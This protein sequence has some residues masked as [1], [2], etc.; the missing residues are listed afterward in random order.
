MCYENIIIIHNCKMS[1]MQGGCFRK[2]IQACKEEKI[3]QSTYTTNKYCWEKNLS[4]IIK[5]KST[6]CRSDEV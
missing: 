2:S 1:K 6:M 5:K 3:K 4:Y